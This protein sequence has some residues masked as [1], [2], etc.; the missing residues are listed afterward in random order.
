MLSY[1]I[2]IKIGENAKL[3]LQQCEMISVMIKIC[4]HVNAPTSNAKQVKACKPLV[5]VWI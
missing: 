2:L 3:S 5:Q 1:Q 4:L